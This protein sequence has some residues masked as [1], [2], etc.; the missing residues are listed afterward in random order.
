LRAALP[1]LL[2]LVA[3]GALAGDPGPSITLTQAVRTALANHPRLSAQTFEKEAA[4][5][6]IL[7]S[8]KRPN[9]EVD[10][11]LSNTG[12]TLPLFSRSE[13]TFA[14]SQPIELGRREPRI[15]RAEAEKAT[16][17]RDQHSVR[18]DVM[19][20]VM[21]AFVTLQGAQRK[22]ALAQEAE[23]LAASL[24]SIA[25]ERV[26]AGAISPIEATRANVAFSLAL[27]DSGRA[28][29]DV[30]TARR[31]LSA[32]MGEPNP[33]FAA[34][35]GE[36]PEDLNVPDAGQLVARMGGNPDLAR[37][38]TER[39][40]RQAALDVEKS[41]ARPD[42]TVKGGVKY[43]RE[44]VETTFLVGFSMPLTLNDRNEGAIR[45]AQ[46]KLSSVELE[47]READVRLRGQLQ[48]RH[49]AMSAA[50]REAATLKA[51]SLAGA[52]SAYDAVN[53]GYRLGKFRYLDVL[54]AGK[55]LL[56]TRM[57]YLEA[58]IELNLARV[59]VERLVAQLPEEGGAKPAAP[60]DRRY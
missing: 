34:A 46:A 42:V 45:E 60:A 28:A 57:R 6:R 51:E 22:M 4:D 39:A 21:R 50:A 41:L 1:L 31:E 38:D 7:Q 30:E 33:S 56:E 10:V 55:T 32:A 25:G 58:I 12:G 9:P 52:Q 49:A 18:F 47:R 19:S 44:E 36:L 48:V 43:L 54:D 20:A 16:L 24:K 37:W 5:G 2:T 8:S 14:F 13:T 23:A 29:R 27:A 11:E 53:E 59:D 40:Q 3:T 35:A 15:R 26:A 17:G